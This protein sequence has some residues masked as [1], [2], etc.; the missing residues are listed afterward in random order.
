MPV[1]KKFVAAVAM[2]WFI[3]Q[4]SPPAYRRVR[5]I[6]F[7]YVCDGVDRSG[8]SILAEM[9]VLEG[10]PLGGGVS[11]GRDRRSEIGVNVRIQKVTNSAFHIGG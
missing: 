8:A 6:Q 10:G 3:G 4:V 7:V 5:D 1:K 11:E 2:R 9:A